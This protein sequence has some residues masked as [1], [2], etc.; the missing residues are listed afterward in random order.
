MTIFAP[1]LAAFSANAM[2]FSKFCSVIPMLE[3]IDAMAICSVRA[4][5]RVFMMCEWA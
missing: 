4:C 3:L 5:V 2:C 1:C